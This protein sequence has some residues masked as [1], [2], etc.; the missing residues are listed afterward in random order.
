ECRVGLHT[1]RG[2]FS[3]KFFSFTDVEHPQALKARRIVWWGH[4]D[5]HDLT[6]VNSARFNCASGYEFF[7][8]TG[9]K[10]IRK[11]CR[12]YSTGR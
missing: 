4:K 3:S 11:Q 5:Q 7:V 9:L 12:T 6:T 1:T 8:H 2:L 10:Q